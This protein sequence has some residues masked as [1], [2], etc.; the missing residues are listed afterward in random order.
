MIVSSLWAVVTVKHFFFP[1][2]QAWLPKGIS[3]GSKGCSCRKATSSGLILENTAVPPG[4]L[5]QHRCMRSGKHARMANSPA[6]MAMTDVSDGNNDCRVHFGQLNS[7]DVSS[8]LCS[9]RLNLA[10]VLICS[11]GAFWPTFVNNSLATVL[12]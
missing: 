7:S 9:C 2:I 4:L 12:K 6:M 5:G 8:P 11:N 10:N 1:L 3:L